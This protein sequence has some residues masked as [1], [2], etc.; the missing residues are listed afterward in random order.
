MARNVAILLLLSLVWAAPTWAAKPAGSEDRAAAQTLFDEGRKLGDKG[1]W[2][3]AC[4]KFQES[5]RLHEAIGTQLNLARCFEQIDKLASAWINWVEAKQRATAAGQSK[6]VK[7]ASERAAALEGRLS[8]ITIRVTQPL[9]DMVV[10]R[11]GTELGSAQW[12]TKLPVDGGKHRIVVTAA[13]HK[14]WRKKIRIKKEGVHVVVRVPR[15]E[16]IAPPTATVPDPAPQ[17]DPT[18]EPTLEPD[19]IPGPNDSEPTDSRISAQFLGGVAFT[20]VGATGLALGIG[21]GVAAMNANDASQTRCPV[22][23]VECSRAGVDLRVKAFTF[24]YVSTS[25][26]AA[27]G[28]GL[29][30]GVILMATAPSDGPVRQGVTVVPVPHGVGVGATF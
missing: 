22:T 20:V 1:D 29:L 25:G 2:K 28:A 15:L 16:P 30:I 17:P 23:P 8:Y 7:I 24:S 21:F 4:V 13:G 3:A 5:L 10:T 19:E 26:F 6:R 27:A 9:E 18:P 14:K 11:D 12:D